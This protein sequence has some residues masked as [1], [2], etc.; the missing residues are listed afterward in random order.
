MLMEAKGGKGRSEGRDRGG[1]GERV[2][3]GSVEGVDGERGGAEGRVGT[4]R[5][6]SGGD[7]ER[8]V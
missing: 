3:A 1:V 2:R 4:G 8:G 7:G 5:A 6:G